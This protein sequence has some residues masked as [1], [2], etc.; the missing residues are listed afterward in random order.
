[1]NLLLH[2]V[3]RANFTFY[4]LNQKAL[5]G[6]AG[7]VLELMSVCNSLPLWVGKV[8]LGGLPAVRHVADFRELEV[9]KCK[10]GVTRESKFPRVLSRA[11]SDDV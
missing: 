5:R 7:H 9:Y 1:M 3:H 11:T 8:A 4:M 6:S 2:G 10:G